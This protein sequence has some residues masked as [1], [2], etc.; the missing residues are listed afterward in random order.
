[1][2]ALQKQHVDGTVNASSILHAFQ[3][4]YD[5]AV[6]WSTAVQAL[7]LAGDDGRHAVSLLQGLYAHSEVH[8]SPFMTARVAECAV[9]VAFAVLR[10][11]GA[12]LP[13]RL[14]RFRLVLSAV[15]ASEVR[16]FAHNR[17]LHAV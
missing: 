16:T 9:A 6:P 8:W 5:A 13:D 12:C 3:A 10:A 2:C 11:P 7:L 1:M 15:P 17:D 14:H 4:N